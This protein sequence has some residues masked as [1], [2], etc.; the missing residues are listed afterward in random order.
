MK[1]KNLTN[2]KKVQ[3]IWK[4]IPGYTQLYWVSNLGRIKNKVKILTLTKKKNGYWCIKLSNHCKKKTYFIHRLVYLT[5]NDLDLSDPGIIDHLIDPD[6][7]ALHELRYC[8]NMKENMANENTRL[9]I[10]K[11]SLHRKENKKVDQSL[12]DGE[13]WTDSFY[14]KNK[15]EVSNFGRV[16]NKNTKFILTPILDANGYYRI[17][18][19]NKT[20][21]L[22]R[23]IWESFNNTQIPNIY[24]L[25]HIDSN[26]IN[27]KLDNLEL[28]TNQ[29]NNSNTRRK[30]KEVQRRFFKKVLKVNDNYD[31][32][33]T[34]ESIQEVID[35]EKIPRSTI[36]H[37]LNHTPFIKKN[38][39]Y[40]W[41]ED[42]YKNR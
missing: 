22:H 24:T 36:S 42:F 14:H 26:C 23:L 3:E 29:Q 30:F 31:I 11:A 18:L 37:I 39:F 1:N 25:D 15:Y 28:T 7:N 2:A 16:R 32:V 21:Q 8:K 20:Y 4:E 19:S 33:K 12:I 10:Q 27:N 35:S 38:G 34:Y 5:F 6:H 13:I 40:F 9:K 17:H 41:F